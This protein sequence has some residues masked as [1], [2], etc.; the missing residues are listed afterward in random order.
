MRISLKQMPR[1]SS[2]EQR[3]EKRVRNYLLGITIRPRCA[4]LKQ[5]T[6][7]AISSHSLNHSKKLIFFFLVDEY[8]KAFWEVQKFRQTHTALW[9]FYLV[10]NLYLSATPSPKKQ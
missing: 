10:L 7:Y 1:N 5:L 9:Y 4:T 6:S 3:P 8:T 2:A